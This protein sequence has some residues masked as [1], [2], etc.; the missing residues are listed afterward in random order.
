[1]FFGETDRPPPTCSTPRRSRRRW[2]AHSG[3]PSLI[4]FDAI[5]EGPIGREPVGKALSDGDGKARVEEILA[6][7]A[8]RLKLLEENRDV[9][10]ARRLSSRAMS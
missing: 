5:A 2:S 4:S 10:I 7:S 9:V 1:M 8:R 3:W 6:D